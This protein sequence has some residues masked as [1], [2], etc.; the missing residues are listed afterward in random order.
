MD[1]SN[2]SKPRAVNIPE[3]N[4]TLNPLKSRG[5]ASDKKFIDLYKNNRLFF[6]NGRPYE[7]KYLEESED[8]AP[9]ILNFFSRQGTND[10]KKN[11]FE[12]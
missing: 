6:R 10:V 7:K 3:I 5:W 9:S 8:N 11:Y 1:L 4:L 12:I 2:P